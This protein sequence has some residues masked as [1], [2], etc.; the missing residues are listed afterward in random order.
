MKTQS[1]ADPFAIASE[2]HLKLRAAKHERLRHALLAGD[3]AT[4]KE[5]VSSM[6]QQECVVTALAI[7]HEA[8][9]AGTT[10]KALIDGIIEA[11][12]RNAGT[13]L[14]NKYREAN[15]AFNRAC[16]VFI[17]A[18]KFFTGGA[19]S[20]PGRYGAEYS[21]TSGQLWDGIWPENRKGEVAETWRRCV[22]DHLR[23]MHDLL[24]AVG[25]DNCLPAESLTKAAAE[26]GVS[27]QGDPGPVVAAHA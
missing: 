19:S 27:L 12:K 18:K 26:I 25:L 9:P 11:A 7:G 3:A 20:D 1:Q 14:S 24:N 13:P 16:R 8:S 22:R 23:T 4:C 10:R 6:T 17:D 21:L 2:K 5:V 15:E